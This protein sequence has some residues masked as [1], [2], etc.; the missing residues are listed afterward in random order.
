VA[1]CYRRQLSGR[2]CS[3]ER[4]GQEDLLLGL[5]PEATKEG[6]RCT[7]EC[8]VNGSHGSWPTPRV[9]D[10]AERFDPPSRLVADVEERMETW[11]E[12][13]GICALFQVMT[14]IAHVM[15][16]VLGLGEVDGST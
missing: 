11:V 2:Q 3:A 8:P 4:D 16:L 9:E 15:E 1:Q 6:N 10:T 7:C 12:E 13:I 14:M 5:I